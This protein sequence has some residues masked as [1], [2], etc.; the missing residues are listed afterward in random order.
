VALSESVVEGAGPA[1]RLGAPSLMGTRSSTR[2]VAAL[3]IVFSVAI[4]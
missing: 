3:I 4:P 1:A 2:A